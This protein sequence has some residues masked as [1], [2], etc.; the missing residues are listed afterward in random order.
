MENNKNVKILLCNNTVNGNKCAYRSKCMFAHDLNEQIIEPKRVIIYKMINEYDDLSLV[1]IYNDKELFNEMVI[2][3]KEC[4]NCLAGKC[5]GGYNCKY[6]TFKKELRICNEDLFCGRCQNKI[7]DTLRCKNGIHLTEKK[8]IPYNQRHNI[9]V[10]IKGPTF[11][12]S[13]KIN[14]NSKIRAIS[15]VLT[16]DTLEIAHNILKGNI[17]E[18]DIIK[19][20]RIIHD[21]IINDSEVSKMEN[22]IKK[23]L[24]D[25]EKR[26]EIEIDIIN[27]FKNFSRRK[28]PCI[29]SDS[30]GN[31]SD[32]S[33]INNKFLINNNKSE[34]ES[35]SDN[36]SIISN[37]E[38]FTKEINELKLY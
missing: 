13:S 9:E 12:A 34:S 25:K 14:Y 10:N 6:G 28:S 11:L 7:D 3:T 4:K 8:L 24:E 33:I 38:Q 30:D 16:D 21:Q 32:D 20:S 26:G 31:T 15:M 29:S 22:L 18:E 19:N 27:N 2:L 1:N 37:E 23:N 5:P 36:D 17:S 35:E